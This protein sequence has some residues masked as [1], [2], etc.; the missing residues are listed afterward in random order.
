MFPPAAAIFDLMLWSLETTP[1]KAKLWNYCDQQL[2]RKPITSLLTPQLKSVFMK[3]S[4][5]AV[6][7]WPGESAFHG[8]TV[9]GAVFDRN[10]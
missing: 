5:P 4:A 7:A 6:I 1:L 3:P 2:H 10:T 8:A 9:P